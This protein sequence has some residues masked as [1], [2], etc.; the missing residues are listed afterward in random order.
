MPT[1][2][3]REVPRRK[4]ADHRGVHI[5]FITAATVE[6]T[7]SISLET[8]GRR[9]PMT[10][11]RLGHGAIG[12]QLGQALLRSLHINGGTWTSSETVRTHAHLAATFARWLRDEAGIEDL[13]DRD[14][15]PRLVWEGIRCCARQGG[16]QRNL[17]TL[18]ADAMPHL[19]EDGD[20]YRDFLHARAL[21]VDVHRIEGYS[22]DV[23]RAIE[24]VA[25]NQVADW[26]SRHR[27]V[28][29]A[30]LGALP[31]DWLHLSVEDLVI[32]RE[33]ESSAFRIERGD[34]AAAMVLLAL[35]DDKGPNLATIQSYTSD[36]VERASEDAAFV[37]G[38]KARNR[39]V[40]RTPAPAGG[41]FSYGGLLEFVTAA[42]R[43]DRHFRDHSED[44]DRLLFIP[45]G[46]NTVMSA[47]D[48]NRWWRSTERTR[49][50]ATPNQI[51]PDLLSFRRL[52]KAALLRGRRHGHGI[53][54]QRQASAR[55]Y[56]ADAVP[57]V[58][59][60][61][62]LLET[63][64]S[65]TSYWRTRSAGIPRPND[66]ATET[67][68]PEEIDRLLNA[69][70]VMDVGVAACVSNGQSPI[71]PEKPCGLGPVA[72]FMCPNGFRTPE[73]IPGL[74][75][76]VEFTDNVRKYE[77]QEWLSGEAALLNQLARKTL[78][79]FPQ[80][81]IDAASEEDITN[82]RALIACVYVE[83]RIRG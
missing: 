57:D 32:R 19:R 63:Q 14:L 70:K 4:I 12:D 30:V 77:P 42:T 75:A 58:I 49:V 67:T 52:R 45:T 34:L 36:S 9:A 6:P 16:G 53:I 61:P 29:G 56:L 69:E 28:V 24:E 35:A 59:L 39:Q 71:D 62:G 50:L 7:G 60:I 55:L 41:L 13:S 82:S 20:I 66:A 22:P 78:A 40:L 64:R 68:P 44:F 26:Y 33:F 51:Y 11:K 8:R 74:I 18:L 73:L 72:C 17:R 10:L 46:G 2:T 79:Q 38:V 21:P 1:R 23:A 31:K 76:A 83:T 37:N 47:P 25:R 48:V 5:N 54:G 15:S 43:V 27:K 65:V 80:H 3:D 81:Q